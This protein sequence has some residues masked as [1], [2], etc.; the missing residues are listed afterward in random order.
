MKI[1]ILIFLT[2]YFPQLFAQGLRNTEWTQ[3]KVERKDGSKILDHS[4]AENAVIKYNFKEKTV[5]ISINNIFNSEL[6]YSVNDE[7]LNI[8]DFIKYKI[9]SSNSEILALTQISKKEL[10]DDKLNRYTFLNR[11]SI[12]EYLKNSGKIKIIGDSL[13][14][15]NNYFAPTYFGDI[16]QLII[17]EFE[18]YD[19]N[20]KIYGFYI[21]NS[22]GKIEDILFDENCKLKDNEIA[23]FL[24]MIKATNGSW[25]LPETNKPYKYK[26]NFGV[27]FTSM[28][29]LS[30]VSFYYV[31]K[32]LTQEFTKSLSL[33]EMKEAD[34]YFTKGND[35]IS[36]KKYE[37]ASKQFIKCIEIDSFYIDAYYNLAFC[38]QKL[39]N[40]NFACEIWNKLKIMGQKQGEYLYEETCK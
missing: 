35:L 17:K 23:K 29:P 16:N 19:L 31:S 4:G 33:N 12:F 10:T 14:E 25:F 9:D 28:Q 24:K 6:T 39:D 30:G 15:Y 3:I 32:G 13:I 34:N 2:L 21:L 36:N 40:K 1:I 22:G 5:L 27:D 18:T 7:I 26:I 8:G 20:K 11:H 37:K 38:Y